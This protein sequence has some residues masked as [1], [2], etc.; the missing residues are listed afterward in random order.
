MKHKLNHK[1]FGFLLLFILIV[2]FCSISTSANSKY[3]NSHLSTSKMSDLNDIE[4]VA[5]NSQLDDALYGN[6]IEEDTY[7]QD[8][9]QL[10]FEE[11]AFSLSEIAYLFF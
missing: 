2:S 7:C 9:I 3:D 8:Y 6:E 4:S 5:F 1:V 11:R 10:D